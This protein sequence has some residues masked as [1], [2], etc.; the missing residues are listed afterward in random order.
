MDSFGVCKPFM[1]SSITL[2]FFVLWTL[3]HLSAA[4]VVKVELKDYAGVS[5]WA[6]CTLNKT[7]R[8]RRSLFYN[9]GSIQKQIKCQINWF[10]IC[11]FN[12][13]KLMYLLFLL[14]KN[15]FTDF[16][17][18]FKNIMTICSDDDFFFNQQS[19]QFISH[20]IF[21]TLNKYLLN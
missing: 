15:K 8:R 11:T 2:Y 7:N 21:H 12:L 20:S 9:S 16:A 18:L 5:K 1:H 13:L 3:R 4:F 10:K 19:S 17:W 14:H 6:F